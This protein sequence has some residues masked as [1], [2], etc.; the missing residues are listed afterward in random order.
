MIRMGKSIRHKWVNDS[1]ERLEEQ[2]IE[3]YNTLAN[4]M[5]L[6]IGQCQKFVTVCSAIYHRK[7]DII[8][9]LATLY[10]PPKMKIL[11]TVIPLATPGLA[12]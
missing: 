5:R 7:P 10:I 3:H 1:S 4:I 8:S 12:H 2:G 9:N 6:L 11:N